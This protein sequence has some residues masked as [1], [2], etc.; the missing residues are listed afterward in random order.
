MN[1]FKF[2]TTF[3]NV[4]Y[5]RHFKNRKALE[6][7]QKKCIKRQEKYFLKHSP[8]FRKNQNMNISMDKAFMMKHFN[9]LNTVGI[10]KE[11]A[12]KIAKN[13]EENRDF[14][15]KLKGIAVGLSSGTSGHRGIFLTSK[16]EQA[17]WAGTMLA[18]MLPR[19]KLF[20]HRLAFF[21]RADNELY[22]KVNLGVIKLRYFDMTKDF[23]IHIKNLNEFKPSMLVAPASVLTILSKAQLEN[24]LNI[25][26]L[27]IISVAE[28]L[29]DRDK[30]YIKSA[31]KLK[32]IHQIYQATE[33]FLG[34]GCEYGNIHLNEDIIHFKK[35][36]I[37]E[38]RFYPRI[39]DF[40][41]TS[42][43]FINFLMNDILVEEK[44]PCP[45]GLIFTRIKK[46]EGRADDI[47]KFKNSKGEIISIFPDFIR[48]CLLFVDNIR[49]YQ[50][51]QID[52]NLI[53]VAI[54]DLKEED[55]TSITKEFHKFFLNYDIHNINLE[56]ISYNIDYQRK[57]KR[58]SCLLKE[59]Q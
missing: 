59:V 26:P 18:K 22:K 41:R 38:N 14:S 51:F 56:F 7:Y 31:F 5:I 21:L 39:T 19:G 35:E 23:D 27:K 40:T 44:S 1:I 32:V 52:Y 58:V 12:F 17:A 45:C 50:V 29:E 53:Q 15:T 55:K 33:G 37:D 20:P 34:C 25:N 42:Q 24:R 47:F 28:I 16:S 46:I 30:E 6:D 3:I 9:E 54:L 11:T 49:E 13:S 2:L 8:Y 4:R 10:D 48:R 43:P 36:Y 57:L